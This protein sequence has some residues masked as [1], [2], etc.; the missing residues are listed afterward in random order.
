MRHGTNLL[1]SLEGMSRTAFLI[2]Q[3]LSQAGRSGLTPALLAKKL[4]IPQEEVEYFVD[5]HHGVMYTNLTRICLSP[6][7]L[8]L[9]R[10]VQDGL[11]S[12]GDASF[13]LEHVRA[14]GDA[15]L[16]RLEERLGLDGGASKSA[17]ART[18]LRLLYRTP[19]SI[20]THVQTGDYSP[21][22]KSIFAVVRHSETGSMR[23]DAL[24]RAFAAGSAALESALHELISDYALFE[25]FRFDDE[26]FLYRSFSLLQ[27][28]RD[29]L[30]SDSDER[31]AATEVLLPQRGV[32]EEQRSEGMCFTDLLGR[33]TASIA[34]RPCRIRKDSASLD[35]DTALFKEDRARLEEIVSENHDP[36]L[37]AFMDAAYLM[38]WIKNTDNLCV[39]CDVAPLLELSLLE[40]HRLVVHRLTGGQHAS[41]YAL[42]I[43]ASAALQPEQWYSIHGF[44]RFALSQ[45]DSAGTYSLRRTDTGYAYAAPQSARMRYETLCRLLSQQ[46]TWLGLVERC[47]CEGEACFRVSALGRL[48][49]SDPPSAGHA[50]GYSTSSGT[51]VVQPNFEIMAALEQMDPLRTIPLHIFAE[52]DGKGSVGVF[53]LTR[54]RF[55]RALQQGHDP[56]A[57]L[58]FLKENSRSP[59]PENVVITLQDWLRSAK[60]VRL[61]TY[62]VIESDDPMVIAELAHHRKW[63]GHFTAVNEKKLLRYE[64]LTRQALE[65]ELEKDGYIIR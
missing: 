8:A 26:G 49:F 42:L 64:G 48:L 43:R 14:L 62:H 30:F 41:D 10:R 29:F 3:E 27:E 56:A 60:R 35:S 31:T 53:R 55:M 32:P 6:G 40:R 47:Y 18:V 54:E 1:A 2:V 38:A 36:P 50:E 7:G 25:K 61:R 44:A 20:E 46:L 59:L 39:V 28:L 22:A 51:L 12:R 5:V 19:D 57:F 63:N 15:A 17:L 21:L 16:Q 37:K 34:A 4:E 23:M 65:E 24:R 33:I 52:A 9:A 45:D 11:A 13:L 58:A